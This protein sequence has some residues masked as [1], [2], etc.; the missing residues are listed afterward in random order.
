MIV[1]TVTANNKFFS[2]IRM[3][4]VVVIFSGMLLICFLVFIMVIT[5]ITINIKKTNIPNNENI[6]LA[7]PCNKIISKSRNS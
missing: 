3:K 5:G 2:E 1:T 6:S 7:A 4:Y